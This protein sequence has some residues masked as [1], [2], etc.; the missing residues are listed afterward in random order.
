LVEP[1]PVHY[2]QYKISS[3]LWYCLVERIPLVGGFRVLS[4]LLTKEEVH[5]LWQLAEHWPKS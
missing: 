5:L 1:F 2:F 4:L 3:V